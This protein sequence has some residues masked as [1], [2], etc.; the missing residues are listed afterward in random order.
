MHEHYLPAT[1]GYV[2]ETKICN[3]RDHMHKNPHVDILHFTLSG[4]WIAVESERGS[5]IYRVFVDGELVRE[6]ISGAQLDVYL[7][8]LQL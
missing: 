1:T 4:H 2:A 6:Q 5:F 3:E 8:E 7:Q